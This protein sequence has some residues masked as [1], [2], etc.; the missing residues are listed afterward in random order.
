MAKEKLFNKIL[1][2]PD[3]FKGTLTAREVAE[4][5]SSTISQRILEAEI[6]TLPIADGGD[7]SLELLLDHG[8]EAIKVQSCNA[9]MEPTEV[10]YGI[11]KDGQKKIAFLEMAQICGIA[12]LKGRPKEPHFAS[13]YGLGE[14]AYQVLDS[15]VDEIIVSVGGS[16]STDGGV[17]FLVGL[18]A[19]I[20][21]SDGRR[22][23]PNLAGLK[24]IQSID[25]S[26]LHH[27]TQQVEWTFLVD[28]SNPLVGKNGAAYVYGPQKG[29]KADEL[30]AA[31]ESL[32][33]W[34]DILEKTTGV[35]VADLPGAGA[36][37][38]IGSLA[39][40]IFHSHFIPGSEWFS[41]HLKLTEKI[42]EANLIITGEGSFDSQSVQGKGPGFVLSRSKELAKT[43]AVLA[44]QIDK[45]LPELADVPHISLAEIA[46]DPWR[47]I[48]E[49][50]RWLV[51]ATERLLEQIGAT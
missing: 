45:D 26:L 40:S 35:K 17:G 23:A 42:S 25:L 32:R 14:V 4:C 11:K 13:S 41:E 49:P 15:G 16:A 30:E 28:V 38:G 10:T 51:E 6:T 39:S 7:G 21:N 34:G 18:G 9:L 31:D 48:Q 36:A 43:V 33:H 47:A 2:A 19:S 3:K 20:R 44:G 27:R 46:G 5:I 1:V 24:E 37:G 8:Y 12:S 22:V 50:H 29:L